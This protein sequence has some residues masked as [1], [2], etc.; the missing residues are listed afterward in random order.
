MSGTSETSGITSSDITDSTATGRSVITAADAAAARTAIGAGT[1]NLALGTTSSTALAGNT[2]LNLFT[3]FE[4][5]TADGTWSKP[6]GVTSALVTAVGGG[7]SAQNLTSGSTRA[8]A[9]G[10]G[11]EIQILV[12]GL[13]TAA[14]NYP[15]VVGT[16]VT[17]TSGPTGAVNGNFTSIGNAPFAVIARAGFTVTSSTTSTQLNIGDIVSREALDANFRAPSGSIILKNSQ[18]TEVIHSG[19]GTSTIRKSE[20]YYVPSPTAAPSE[21]GSSSMSTTTTNNA[22]GGYIS[23]RY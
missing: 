9:L 6:A 22:A 20:G 5:F 12:R 19:F 4:E 14:T 1:S 13:P 3:N 2:D 7:V 16:V 15:L 8:L 21:Y 23:I 17:D 18:V 10:S 11:D